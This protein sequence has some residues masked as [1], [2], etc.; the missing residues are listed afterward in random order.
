MEPLAWYRIAIPV[1]ACVALGMAARYGH[2]RFRFAGMGLIAGVCFGVL[3]DQ[4]S[5]RLCPEYF[6][7][8]H[9]PIPGLN[10]PTLMGISWGFLGAWWA[11]LFLGYAAG[12]V[13][14]FGTLPKLTPRDVVRH[15]LFLMLYVGATVSAIGGI[16]WWHAELLGV[17]I[18]PGLGRL[19]PPEHHRALLVVSCYHFAAYASSLCGSVVLCAWIWR[20]RVKRRAAMLA[21]PSTQVPQSIDRTFE[22]NNSLKD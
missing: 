15:L 14:T 22:P 4:V 9:P 21:A 1:A 17:S 20:E 12:L 19:L 7:L 10:D 13:A 8:F 2:A 16:V 11:G 6:T 3:Q 18:D 5:A